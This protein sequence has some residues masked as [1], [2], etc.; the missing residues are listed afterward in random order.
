MISLERPML[1]TRNI[2][3]KKADKIEAQLMREY[4]IALTH[5]RDILTS[6]YSQ[7]GR[8]ISMAIVRRMGVLSQVEKQ[9]AAILHDTDTTISR[10]IDNALALM[11]TEDEARTEWALDNALHTRL[12]FSWFSGQQAYEVIN[13][14]LRY[15]ADAGIMQR[16]LQR[17]TR[18]LLQGIMQGQGYIEMA[19]EMGNQMSRNLNEWTRVFRTEGHRVTENAIVNTLDQAETDGVKIERM[20]VAVLDD[21]T[22]DQSE[23]MDGQIADDEG[24][25]HY[26]DTKDQSDI[27]ARV[28]G[29]TGVPE[30][31]INDRE[32]VIVNIEGVTDQ[33]QR[34]RGEGIVPRQNF[35]DW[36]RDHGLTESI[37]GEEYTF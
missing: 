9:L 2:I 36:A 37:Y 25:F 16:G 32:T 21:R 28:P 3:K 11:Y 1:Q 14:P 30:Y 35:P 10:K 23:S 31:D 18:T 17:I 7:I 26:P 4:R 27:T 8:D 33:F 20:L 15:L 5:V 19:R 6:L 24:Y 29:E 22:R 12:N 13:N 34:V